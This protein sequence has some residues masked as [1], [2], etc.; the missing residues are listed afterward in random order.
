MAVEVAGRSAPVAGFGAE[1]PHP[2]RAVLSEAMGVNLGGS[3]DIF[4]GPD[5]GERMKLM[6]SGYAA[7]RAL[8]HRSAA[9]AHV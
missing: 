6:R 4:D 2:L 9:A 3:V 8:P 7:R 1:Q 5:S